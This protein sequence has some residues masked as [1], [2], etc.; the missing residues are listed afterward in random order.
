MTS[1]YRYSQIKNTSTGTLTSTSR[2]NRILNAADPIFDPASDQFIG[3]T[4]PF[5]PFGDYRVPIPAN[6]ATVNFATVHPKDI[7]TSKVW[8]LDLNIYT[9]QLFKLPAG[10]VGLAFGGQFRRENIDPGSRRTKCSGRHH[11]CQS[12][13]HYSRWS[14]GFRILCGD[15][16]SRHQPGDGDSGIPLI[17]VHGRGTL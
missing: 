10:G 15:R 6:A 7:D 13:C 14:Q 4:V 11:R 2:F 9:T 12:H 3:T 5:N 8:T 1:A 17:G 16:H